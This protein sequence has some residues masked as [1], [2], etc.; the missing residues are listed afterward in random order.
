M[1]SIYNKFI[2][3]LRDSVI[4]LNVKVKLNLTKNASNVLSELQKNSI[5]PQLWLMIKK[6]QKL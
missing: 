4:L 5:I 1:D 3:S 2:F 6:S